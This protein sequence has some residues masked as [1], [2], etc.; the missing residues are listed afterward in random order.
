M[1][2][3]ADK[4]KARRER[5]KAEREAER[6]ETA[7]FLAD[8][9]QYR[10]LCEARGLAPLKLGGQWEITIALWSL[11]AHLIPYVSSTGSIWV[12]DLRHKT[13]RKDR[14]FAIANMEALRA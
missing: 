6:A 5:V 12:R 2:T 13:G 3:A 14:P 9:E 4:A 1:T 11:S 8:Y 7:Q 10:A